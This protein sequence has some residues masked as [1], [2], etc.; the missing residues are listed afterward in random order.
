MK[1]AILL[2][3]VLLVATSFTKADSVIIGT[4]SFTTAANTYGPM[5]SNNTATTWNRNAYIYPASLLGT[6]ANNASISSLA[7]YRSTGTNLMTAANQNFKIY[8]KN[9]FMADFGASNINWLDTS[10]TMTLVYNSD[11]SSIVT[12]NGGFKTFPFIAPY[13]YNTSNGSNLMI[14]VEYTQTTA[15]ATTI[16]WVYD[17]SAGVPAYTTNQHKYVGGTSGSPT[18]TTNAANE[19]HPYIT[20]NYTPFAFANDMG[21][22]ASLSPLNLASLTTGNSYDIYAR[23]KNFGTNSQSGVNV[24]YKVDGGTAVGPV[25][26]TGTMNQNDTQMV[27]FTGANAYTALTGNHTIKIYTSLGSDESTVNDTTTI[28]VG[29]SPITSF[30]WTETFTPTI[31]WTATSGSLWGIVTVTTQANGAGGQAARANCYNVAAGDL[32]TLISPV[33]NLTGITHP[34]LTFSLAYCGYSAAEDD[35]LQVF[36]SSDGGATWS[37]ALYQKSALSSPSLQTIPFSTTQYNPQAK[38]DWKSQIVDLAAYA[39]QSNLKVGFC[40]TSQFGNQICIDNISVMNCNNYTSALVVATGAQT[41]QF[42][43]TVNFGTIIPNGTLRT[44]RFTGAPPYS[45]TQFATN[46]TATT[47]DGSIFTPDRVSGDF[48]FTVDYDSNA[49]YSISI[50]LATMGGVDNINKLYILKRNLVNDSWTALTTTAAGTVLTASGLTS[51]SDFA[52]GGDL[53]NQLPVELSSFT[54]S[55]SGKNVLLKWSTT[56]EENN[57]GFNIE[58][59]IRNTET[60]TNSGFVAGNGNSNTVK[61]YS[62]E[63]KNLST[64]GY[65]YRLKQVDYNGNYRYYDLTNEVIVGIPTKFAISQNYPNPFNPSTKINYELPF[66]SKVSIKIFDITGR[67]M[68][69]VVNEIQTAGY[70]TTNFNASFLSSG[71]Y[72]YQINADG[73][74]QNFVKTMKMMLIK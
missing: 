39:G 20:I 70:Y 18:N 40:A 19:R 66:D 69:S 9:T 59:R 54:S 36:V 24:Y 71:V 3:F 30:P 64:G 16:L 13:T 68:A 8:I 7:F 55:V 10:A 26:T 57:S 25:T 27:V 14:L 12:A 46:A 33:L 31:G 42:E 6:M 50:D 72:F 62:F 21:V 60:W 43:T 2:F 4:G 23:T 49:S 1:K 53:N 37:A 51:F 22:T 11:P 44:S 32:D 34:V 52:I 17:S 47:Q 73:G 29:A 15:L 61:N 63:D 28:Q 35:A 67:E 5:R 45:G 74:N 65:S 56:M 58:R 48:W 38:G 41:P